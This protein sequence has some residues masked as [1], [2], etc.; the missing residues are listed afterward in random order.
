MHC[1]ELDIRLI[2]QLNPLAE[3]VIRNYGVAECRYES[4]SRYNPSSPLS[5]PI[6][7]DFEPNLVPPELGVK[8]RVHTLIMQRRNYLFKKL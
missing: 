5:T 1:F 7:G 3:V 2:P 4:L 8:G 6:L